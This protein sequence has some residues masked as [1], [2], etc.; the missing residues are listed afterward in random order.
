MGTKTVGWAGDI[1]TGMSGG[2]DNQTDEVTGSG[3]NPMGPS[4]TTA[5][6]EMG[7]DANLGR[8]EVVIIREFL[9]E[10]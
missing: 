1:P 5:W 4:T 9:L 7:K 2:N 10:D 6:P 8:P 3:G